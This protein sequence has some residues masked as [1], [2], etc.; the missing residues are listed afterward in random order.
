MARHV[1][2][3]F[4][5]MRACVRIWAC[6]CV[7]VR[8]WTCACACVDMSIRV[9]ARFRKPC[10]RATVR[11][12]K[13]KPRTIR[14]QQNGKPKRREGGKEGKEGKKDKERKKRAKRDRR[15]TVSVLILIP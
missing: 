7:H 4:G 8:E 6:M 1:G 14:I 9:C 12:R 5:H 13:G 2:D 10:D 3:V 15:H 11:P